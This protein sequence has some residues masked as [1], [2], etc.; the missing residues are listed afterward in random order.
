MIE[1]KI[2]LAQYDPIIGA[3]KHNMA[4]MVRLAGKARDD[5]CELVIFPELA[6]C[7]YPP[8]DLLERK[9]FIQ[10]NL[11]AMDWL[12]S[13]VKRIACLLYTSPSPRDS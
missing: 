5:G 1:V 11:Q 8:R 12:M 4:Q 13:E 7:G 10:D 6:V 3:F 2:G 9:E